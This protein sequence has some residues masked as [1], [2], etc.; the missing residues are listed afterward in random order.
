[1]VWEGETSLRRGGRRSICEGTLGAEN[2]NIARDRGVSG[3]RGSEV[4]TSGRGEE[5]IVGVY[6]DVFVERGKEEG[7]EDFLGDSGRSRRHR[8]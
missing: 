2:R 1:M 4:F 5:D 7:V 6:G 3:H 8:L